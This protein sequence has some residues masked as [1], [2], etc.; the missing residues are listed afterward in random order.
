M[1][2]D[3]TPA[4]VLTILD[5]AEPYTPQAVTLMRESRATGISPDMNAIA[6]ATSDLVRY[7]KA[8]AKFAGRLTTLDP[9]PV[10]EPRIVEAFSL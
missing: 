8:C 2:S 9:V 5:R 3:L 1:A 10:E 7:T 4:D 6:T